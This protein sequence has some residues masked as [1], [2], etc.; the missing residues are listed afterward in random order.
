[1]QMETL[2]AWLRAP[3]TLAQ[4]LG[5]RFAEGR[6]H[7]ER[8]WDMRMRAVHEAGHLNLIHLLL[9]EGAQPIIGAHIGTCRRET[10]E[11]FR[12]CGCIPLLRHALPTASGE[13]RP[14]M[15][16]RA[17]LLGEHRLNVA[18]VDLAGLAAEASVY[19]PCVEANASLF[20][21]PFPIDWEDVHEPCRFARAACSR[22]SERATEQDARNVC[23]RALEDLTELFRGKLKEPLRH[24]TDYLLSS[25]LTKDD[26]HEG[27]VRRLE[28]A[29]WTKDALKP[30]REIARSLNLIETAGAVLDKSGIKTD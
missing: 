29:G 9:P 17:T 25:P 28:A 11:L 24:A 14:T 7:R 19:D 27:F 22:R 26:C 10:Y 8:Q 23:L 16:T 18:Y 3:V 13:L 6:L 4:E 30:L 15:A 12:Q 21:A 20:Q 2:G 1:M 5:S